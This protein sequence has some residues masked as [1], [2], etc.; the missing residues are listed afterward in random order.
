MKIRVGIAIYQSKALFKGFCHPSYN[1]NFIKG[2]LRNLKKKIHQIKGS[3][4]P[5]HLDNSRCS[6][7]L[8]FHVILDAA[9]IYM[10]KPRRIFII[11]NIFCL[12]KHI[13]ELGNQLYLYL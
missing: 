3:T 5:D 13:L 1:F 6:S 12:V 10:D 11:F 8:R 9:K 4:I 7:F 2:I